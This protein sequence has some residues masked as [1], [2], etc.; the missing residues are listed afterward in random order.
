MEINEIEKFSVYESMK[1]VPSAHCSNIIKL[2]TGDILCSFYA[3]QFEKSPDVKIYIS[4][5]SEEGQ[6]FGASPVWTEPRVVAYTPKHSSGNPV[7][8]E[9][10]SGKLFL[11]WQSMHN[12]KI[13]KG[14][15]TVCTIKYQC[16]EDFGV[17]WG[18]WKFLRRLWGY[19]T[20]CRAIISSNGN[21][22][23]P[24]HREFGN[25]ICRFYI[26]DDPELNKLPK[27]RGKISSRKTGLLEPCIFEYESNHL[28]CYMRSNRVKN[29]HIAHSYDDGYN[30]T[31]LKPI[32]LPNPNSQVDAIKLRN[33]DILLAF[34]NQE[35]GRNNLSIAISDDGGQ[36][37][38]H[39][40]TIFKDKEQKRG[41]HYPSLLETDDK[42]IHLTY[43]DNRER[44][45][46]VRFTYNWIYSKSSQILK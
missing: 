39:I 41:F 1:G 19:V 12:G 38:K 46:Y 2:S 26:S 32:S 21:F 42:T 20:R 37:Y 17:N 23:L 25:Y 4:R 22:I 33:G 7:L 3:G 34:N 36:T 11:F 45:G 16:S 13:I 10:P 5:L 6:R 9:T 35:I 18:D 24:V 14:G 44:I 28:I 43:T 27:L 40:K 8:Y 30:W 29:I 31:S 15:W